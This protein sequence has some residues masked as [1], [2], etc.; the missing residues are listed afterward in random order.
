MH[1][2][3]CTGRLT[4]GHWF[5]SLSHGGPDDVGAM[6]AFLMAMLLG[7]VEPFST[8]VPELGSV[9]QGTLELPEGRHAF[10]NCSNRLGITL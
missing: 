3:A 2:L 6:D 1:P 9:V 5:T 10:Q 4:Y 7:L 8:H